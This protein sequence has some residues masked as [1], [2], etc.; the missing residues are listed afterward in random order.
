[1]KHSLC[2]HCVPCGELDSA[3]RRPGAPRGRA[4]KFKV[5]YTAALPEGGPSA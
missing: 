2:S 4:A 5:V 3:Y 1:M